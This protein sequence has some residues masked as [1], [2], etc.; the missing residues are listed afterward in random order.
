MK[1][2]KK[3]FAYFVP[4]DTTGIQAFLEKQAR[5]GWML[6]KTGGAIWNFRR[7]E[8][9]SVHFSVVFFPNA[10]AFDP[11]PSEAQ[12]SFV[13]FCAHTGWKLASSDGNGRSSTTK[14][15]TPRPSRPT[16]PWRW[17]RSTERPRRT[18]CPPASRF[19][20]CC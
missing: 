14:P 17:T 11:A 18:I 9:K 4:F 8:P 7:I 10:S 20:R 19:W 2:T 12:Q 1:Q 16:R 6:E 13:D 15:Q 5:K 3:V